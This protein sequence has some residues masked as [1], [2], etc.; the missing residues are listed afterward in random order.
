[1]PDPDPNNHANNNGPT[2]DVIERR[3]WEWFQA[4]VSRQFGPAHYHLLD[5]ALSVHWPDVVAVRAHDRVGFEIT[6]PLRPE[7]VVRK[8]VMEIVDD[9]PEE[10]PRALKQ[11]LFEQ[12]IVEAISR[13]IR[14]YGHHPL[15]EPLALLITLAHPSSL[16][17]YSPTNVPRLAK[18][19]RGHLTNFVHQPI[20][21]IYLVGPGEKA[22]LLWRR[23]GSKWKK[24]FPELNTLNGA[25]RPS[26]PPPLHRGEGQGMG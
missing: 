20:D 6:S 1:M 14:K 3:T 19:V 18:I 22:Y 2:N 12:R 9:D 5:G 24:L 8:K 15:A 17:F 23:R 16:K 11:R 13:K 26:T 21:A 4:A 10:D 25:P 7:D